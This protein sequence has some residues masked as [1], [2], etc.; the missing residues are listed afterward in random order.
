MKWMKNVRRAVLLGLAGMS[1]AAGA[2]AVAQSSAVPTRL[3]M[4]QIQA[5]VMKALDNKRFKDVKA[6]VQNGVV[7]LTGDGGSLQ[8]E[9]G[10]G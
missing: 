7:T 2:C 1:I 8:R 6:S 3:A 4:R 10:C 9:A 5:D